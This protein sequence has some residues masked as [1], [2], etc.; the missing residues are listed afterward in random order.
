[1]DKI[2][3]G[4]SA[5]NVI[6]KREKHVEQHSECPYL[7]TKFGYSEVVLWS[8][9]DNEAKLPDTINSFKT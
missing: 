6:I 3:N 2:I 4:H 9:V 1:M 5:P 7:K 8:N